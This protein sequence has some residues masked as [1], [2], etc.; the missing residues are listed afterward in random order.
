MPATPPKNPFP[1]RRT[2]ARSFPFVRNQLWWLA[3]VIFCILANAALD[4][5]MAPLTQ[6]A[7][8]ITLAGDL[9]RLPGHL[10][11]FTAAVIVLSLVVGMLRLSGAVLSV[12]IGRDARSAI[13]QHLSLLPSTYLEK[14]H[15]GDLISRITRD[16]GQLEWFFS[17]M[18][19][20]VLYQPLVLIGSAAYLWYIDWR[21]MLA[22]SALVPLGILATEM[23][24]R[25]FSSLARQLADLHGQVSTASSELVGG[26]ATVKSF[27]LADPFS[28]R[29]DALVA[30]VLGKSL[31]L[32]KYDAAF[33]GVRNV[34]RIFPILACMTFGGVLA[35]RGEITAGEL[36]ACLP[37]LGYLTN[38]SAGSTMVVYVMRSVTGGLSRIVELLDEPAERVDGEAF[39]IRAGV[40]PVKFENVG[41]SYDGENDVL[42]N[43]DFEV[44]EGQVVAV[45][46]PSGGGKSTITKLICGMREPRIGEV[47]IYGERLRDWNLSAL[48]KCISIVT[49]EAFLFPGTILENIALGK[50]GC[51]REEIMAAARL[52]QTHEFVC[53]LPDG[54]ETRVGE[55][56]VRLSGGQK[57]R[58]TIARAVIKN[59]PILILDEPTSSLDAQTEASVQEALNR[60]M[61]GRSVLVIAHRLS[62]VRS[63]DKT[64]VIDRGRV[65]EQGT[66]GELMRADSLYRRLY[67]KQTLLG[68]MTAAT[69]G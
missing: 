65:S 69:N 16:T 59:A 56:G 66:H 32:E 36:I 4:I 19:G 22:A 68:T 28:L 23:L 5:L 30:Q 38:A 47:K 18:L 41:F 11:V 31:S 8:D 2:L 49:Q 14:M 46:G 67:L 48:R 24:T 64:I 6:R 9:S 26:M 62:T 55:R 25:S 34:L 54:Y 29:F 61:E 50:P 40:P 3:L 10:A 27:C 53:G 43:V 21:L 57:Q 35:A 42:R 58:I 13:A 39:P 44:A 37:L 52:S 63:A 51:S 33:G 45:V 12:N 20:N 60:L 1:M 7:V 15:S 17:F